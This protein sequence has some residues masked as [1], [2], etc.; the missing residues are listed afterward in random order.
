VAKQPFIPAVLFSNNRYTFYL[1][2]SFFINGIGTSIYFLTPIFLS[3]VQKLS[4]FWIGFA[5]VPATVA[6]AILGRNGGK[7]AD[8]KGNATLYFLSSSLLV[9]CFLLLS[10]FIGSPAWIVAIILVLGNVGQSFMIIVMLNSTSQTLPKDQVGVGM[11]I[12]Q[13]LNFISQGVGTAIYSSVVDIGSTVRWNPISM[14]SAGYVYSNI[15]FALAVLHIF[16]FFI[17]S[18][19]FGRVKSNFYP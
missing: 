11:G 2:L 5:M 18:Y 8:S 13:M 12:L 14:N 6:S 7:L 4:T 17:Y 3:E 9:I 19:Q 16:I 10:S 1:V 15:F